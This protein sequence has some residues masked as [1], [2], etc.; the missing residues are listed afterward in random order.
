MK[1]E[2]GLQSTHNLKK[3]TYRMLRKLHGFEFRGAI[4]ISQRIGN[5]DCVFIFLKHMSNTIKWIYSDSGCTAEEVF[6]L[7]EQIDGLALSIQK[8]NRVS[9][10][11]LV[12]CLKKHTRTFNRLEANHIAINP[13]NRE[14]Q[15]EWTTKCIPAYIC[16]F[17]NDI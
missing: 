5:D 9:R 4:G 17:K 7:C 12:A 16:Q 11:M 13:A 6:N 3:S 10:S 14:V 2:Q 1:L 15:E 8:R